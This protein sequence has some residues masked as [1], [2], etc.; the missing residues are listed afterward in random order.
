MDQLLEAVAASRYCKQLK[1]DWKMSDFVKEEKFLGDGTFSNVHLYSEI[2]TGKKV[3]LKNL[4]KA[5]RDCWK[6]TTREILNLAFLKHPNI[7][8]LYG[9]FCDN[10]C[11]CIVLEYCDSSDLYEIIADNGPLSEK[12]AAS[13]SRDIT[14]A[15][16]YCHENNIYHRDIKTENIV[17]NSTACTSSPSSPSSSASNACKVAKLC[18]FGFSVRVTD[19]QA[20]RSSYCG[21]LEYIPPE[22]ALNQPHLGA[23]VDIWSLGIA[24]FEMVGGYTPFSAGKELDTLKNIEECKV[25]YPLRFSIKLRD[26]L[27][28]M[29]VL[30]PE[31]RITADQVLKHEWMMN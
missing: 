29:L 13:Y 12:Q 25:K 19:R 14:L 30:L 23:S 8:E 17:I 21:T 1:T 20:L 3:A 27:R 22:I 26:L 10:G 16:R 15:L 7:V 4:S 28:N 31:A 11:A 6:E 9:F 2:A 24:I 18:D 5:K